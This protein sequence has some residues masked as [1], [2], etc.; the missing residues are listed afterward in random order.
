MSSQWG[1]G[2]HKG[3]AEG[4]KFGEQAGEAK[5]QM[6]IGMKALCLA[7]SIRNAQKSG[8]VIQYVLTDVLIEMLEGE[9]GEVDPVETNT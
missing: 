4:V 9:C 3:S 7:V 2:F 6:A 5:A 1:H 8:S